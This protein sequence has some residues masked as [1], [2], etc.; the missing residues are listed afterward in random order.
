VGG[1][2][3]ATLK[4]LI[5]G[6][7][8]RQLQRAHFPPRGLEPAGPRAGLGG[9][10]RRRVLPP[11]QIG[12]IADRC[13]DQ[14]PRTITGVPTVAGQSPYSTC[15]GRRH[16][17]WES[18]LWRAGSRSTRRAQRTI[19]AVGGRG[20][21][22]VLL[23][24]VSDVARATSELNRSWS[25]IVIAKDSTDAFTRAPTSYFKDRVRVGIA[26]SFRRRGLR[27]SG[28]RRPLIPASS[29]PQ[30]RQGEPAEHVL[31]QEPRTDPPR[32]PLFDK[33]SATRQCRWAFGP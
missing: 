17:E 2:G 9:R 4:G 6:G 5:Q 10:A 3:I 18:D 25:R 13:A 28:P 14:S 11:D 29:E 33:P 7:A 27:A 23:S 26:R 8:R 30:I 24:L 21:A 20:V 31:R 22:A 19:L 15:T 12:Y 32:T 1:S 16:D